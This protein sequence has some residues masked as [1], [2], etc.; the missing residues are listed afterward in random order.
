MK[1]LLKEPR[2]G[3]KIKKVTDLVENI[4]TR[5]IEEPAFLY[6]LLTLKSYDYY[7]YTHS[8][9]VAILAI[10]LGIQ[11]KMDK[12]QIQKLGIGAI[13]HDLGKAEIPHEILNKQGKLTDVEYQTIKQHV[14]RGYE[15]LKD[16]KDLPQES[17]NVVL[18]H[19]E[20]L[21]GK[22]YLYGLKKDEISIFSK[23]TSI[24]DCYDALPTRRP[25]KA[26]LL[27]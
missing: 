15:L 21:T 9:N 4:I 12:E 10:G 27:F 7:T 17:L 13:L 22:G 3:E 25:Y 24:A 23:I 6:S 1:A 8:I 5:I 26:P 2:S 11:M 20:K 14:I 19:H 16:N 18:Q